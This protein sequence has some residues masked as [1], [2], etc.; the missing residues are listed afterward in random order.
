MNIFSPLVHN[1]F[2]FEKAKKIFKDTSIVD[3]TDFFNPEFIEQLT[4]ETLNV[5][6]QK[7]QRKDFLMAH[8]ENT[9]RKMFS[10]SE[11]A[12]YESSKLI[13]DFYNN[14]DLIN[15][16]TKMAQEKVMVLPWTGERYVINGLSTSKDTHGWHWDDYSYALVFIAKAPEKHQGGAVEC[17]P[18][19]V[20]NR[21]NPNIREILA[22]NE[23]YKHYFKDGSF[24][25]M[26]SDT[27]LHRVAPI[28][29]DSLRV[30]IAMSWCNEKD[31]AKEIDHKT[32]YELYGV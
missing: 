13:P 8:T 9:P 30:A 19:T 3:M 12:I 1:K 15:F 4:T 32:V 25:F 31:L 11:K 14:Q 10:V 18:N 2:A 27:T 7:L 26:K 22:A 17:I 23:P 6:E 24:Y 5:F 29:E 16:L 28:T 21:K 20:W